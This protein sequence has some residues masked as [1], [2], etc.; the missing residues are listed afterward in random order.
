MADREPLNATFYAFRKREGG[1]L[2]GATLTYALLSTLLFAGFLALMWNGLADSIGWFVAIAEQSEGGATPQF[3]PPPPGFYAVIGLYLLMLFPL[4]LLT[5][6]FEAGCLR[7]MLRGERGGLFG[8]SLNADAWRCYGGYWVWFGI[9]LASSLVVGILALIIAAAA[10][11]G[12]DAAQAKKELVEGVLN[13]VAVYFVIRLAPANAAS[14]GLQRFDFFKGWTVTRDRF[15]PLLG[16]YVLLGLIYV[17]VI[18]VIGGI[19]YLTLW[20]HLGPHLSQLNAEQDWS[21]TTSI[22]RDAF[23]NPSD[24]V[25]VCIL[26]GVL[27]ATMFVAYVLHFGICARAVDVALREEKI[28]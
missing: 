17:L 28:A 12:L 19:G 1:L 6:S 21:V 14:V 13:I 26:G 5:A 15:L 11:G 3:T 25:I 22:W 10:L 20:P 8:L 2:L 24:I 7:W 16:S 23:A 4:Y 18:A 9:N 27:I